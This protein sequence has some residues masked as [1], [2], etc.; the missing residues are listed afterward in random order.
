MSGHTIS[1]REVREYLS[2]PGKSKD[3]SPDVVISIPRK[4]SLNFLSLNGTEAI[5]SLTALS[6]LQMFYH[7]HYLLL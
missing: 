7:Y 4:L 1:Y 6:F 5:T 3:K 2:L